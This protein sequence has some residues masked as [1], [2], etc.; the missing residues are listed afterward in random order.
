MCF[1][2]SMHDLDLLLSSQMRI[3]SHCSEERSSDGVDK[4]ERLGK[5]A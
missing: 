5:I 3:F 1:C 4:Y 2:I